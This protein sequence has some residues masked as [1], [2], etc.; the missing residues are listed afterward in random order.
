MKK[1]F[2]LILLLGALQYAQAQ[3]TTPRFGTP[4][5]G[6]NT[7]RQLTYSYATPTYGAT[8]G[9]QPN[10]YETI[11]KMGKL[12]GAQTDTVSVLSSHVGDKLIYIFESD[13]ASA[14]HVVTFGTNFVPS[15]TL[16]VDSAQK[17]TCSFIFDG[18]KF[19]ETARAKQ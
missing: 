2:A 7:G 12:T 6:D 13:T 14:G 10:A 18:V 4:P 3:F 9:V 8:K 11:I 16:T 17:A 1:I 19:I 5:S 15:A